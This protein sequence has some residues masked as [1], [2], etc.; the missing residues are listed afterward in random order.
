MAIVKF[1]FEDKKVKLSLSMGI[2]CCLPDDVI[3]A[4]DVLEKAEEAL[5]MAKG[6]GRG[7]TAVL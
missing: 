5:S 1:S 2:T 4:H 3:D 7:E 6:I